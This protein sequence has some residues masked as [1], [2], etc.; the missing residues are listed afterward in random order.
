MSQ[1]AIGAG[2]VDMQARG[3]S[4]FTRSMEQAS[5]STA[6]LDASM[7]R[8]GS[9]S[10]SVSNAVLK[11]GTAIGALQGAARITQAVFAAVAGDAEKLEQAVTKLP[12]GIGGIFSAFRELNNTIEGTPP[13]LSE[14]NEASAKAAQQMR[15]MQDGAIGAFHATQ[16]LNNG[17]DAQIKLLNQL[18]SFAPEDTALGKYQRTQAE[19]NAAA[20]KQIDQINEQIYQKEK[21][22]RDLERD[23][24]EAI[25]NYKIDREA[26]R[27]RGPL[28]LSGAGDDL[29][30]EIEK[31]KAK[32]DELETAL[33]L[34]ATNK[35][36]LE[37]RKLQAEEAKKTQK[38]AADAADEAQRIRAEL[39]GKGAE[40]QI[41]SIERARDEAI[42]AEEEKYKKGLILEEDLNRARVALNDKA[43]AETMKA[44]SEAA[45]KEA[46]EQKKAQEE[47]FR[48]QQEDAKRYEEARKSAQDA[49]NNTR[50]AEKELAKAIADQEKERAKFVKAGEMSSA[51]E[52][53]ANIQRAAVEQ[54][55]PQVAEQIAIA[56]DQLTVMTGIETAI[57]NAFNE[58]RNR[59]PMMAVM[60]E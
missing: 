7:N 15:Q 22:L 29:K 2:Y 47:A 27:V 48:K 30:I 5:K 8:L 52:L 16:V 37:V 55:D 58:L 59:G 3:A 12:F 41:K 43:L 31:A 13:K 24:A 50:K 46:E 54:M 60:G 28:V 42:K 40:G 11:V 23:Q 49:V 53:T 32:R 45:K 18:A 51:E 39:A 26:G 44:K 17:I 10:D 56:K 35:A 20:Q 38:V 4:E 25:R 6:A 33:K 21:D 9:S 14:V 36:D 19:G 34:A 57:Q 1:V